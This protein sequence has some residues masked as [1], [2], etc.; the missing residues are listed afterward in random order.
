MRP[1]TA[2]S[3]ELG[4][5][6]VRFYPRLTRSARSFSRTE[7]ARLPSGRESLRSTPRT[8]TGSNPVGDVNLC[9]RRIQRRSKERTRCRRKNLYFSIDSF[10]QCIEAIEELVTELVR[11]PDVPTSVRKLPARAETVELRPDAVKIATPPD[12]VPS[13]QTV[14]SV[15][16][17]P[18]PAP[19]MQPIAPAR[20]VE[21]TISISPRGIMEET[22]WANIG[23]M[24]IA[25]PR[26]GQPSAANRAIISAIHGGSRH[27]LLSVLP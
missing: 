27:L 1:E 9:G 15:P 4:P 18:A 22:L 23:E 16:P 24:G 5:D 17:P 12:T 26:P 25:C 20:Y 3:L 21:R 19:V 8:D 10:P 7:G 14:P 11:R 2:P 13:V 6:R